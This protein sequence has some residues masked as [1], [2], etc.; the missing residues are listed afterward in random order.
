MNN[1]AEKVRGLPATVKLA[2]VILTIMV[3][4]AIIVE[5]FITLVFLS[6]GLT[7]GSIM[8]IMVY[9]IEKK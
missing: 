3:I 5:P 7:A 4:A 9:L 1:I 2:I 6:V 8:R